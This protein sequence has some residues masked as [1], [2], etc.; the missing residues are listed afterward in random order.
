MSESISIFVDESGNFGDTRDHSRYCLVTFVFRDDADDNAEQEREYRHGIAQL[1]MDPDAMMFHAGPVIRQEEQFSAMSRHLRGKIFY[2]MLSYVRKSNIRYNTFIVDTKFVSSEEQIVSRLKNDV[3][4]FFRR[5]PGLLD[6]DCR[7]NVYYDAGQK[8]VT[9][10]LF[11]LQEVY[12]S[13][14][15]FIEG[16]QQRQY[17]LLQVADF[18]CMVKLMERRLAEGIAF[19]NSETRFFGSPRDFKRNVLRKVLLKEVY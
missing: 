10:I 6:G 15:V 5:N 4:E 12:G 13:R 9:K 16:V 14:V 11:G 19:N 1:G 17:H 18:I 3:K 2:Q 8:G 7:I